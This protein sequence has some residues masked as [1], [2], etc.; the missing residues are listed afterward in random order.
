MVTRL[1]LG[2]VGVAAAAYGV[3]LLLDLGWDNLVATAAWLV[4]GVLLHDAVLAPATILVCFAGRS[5]GR[6][7]GAFAAG[8][9]ILG[10]IT[11]AAVPVLS[12]GGIRADNPTLL[13]RPYW[14]GWFIVASLVGIGVGAIGLFSTRRGRA[15]H[16]AS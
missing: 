6:W 15:A 8:L 11:L 2:A 16:T 9:L 1:S 14:T 13:D 10:T 5:L 7:R 12:G 3:L 4:G